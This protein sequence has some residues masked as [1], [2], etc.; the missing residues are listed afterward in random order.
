MA[1]PAP[2][3]GNL[4]LTPG[5]FQYATYVPKSSIHIQVSLIA[6]AVAYQMIMLNIIV[7][8]AN[9][10]LQVL[11]VEGEGS[12]CVA[13]ETSLRVPATCYDAVRDCSLCGD[14]DDNLDDS[15][16]GQLHALHTLHCFIAWPLT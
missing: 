13:G 15:L 7:S 3:S 1:S 16:S 4:S 8:S 5:L 12:E 9:A 14:F 6:T 2:P 11:A 10:P